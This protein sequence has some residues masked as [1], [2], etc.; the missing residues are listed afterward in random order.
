MNST[1]S[2]SVPSQSLWFD[3]PWNQY[4][5]AN[6]DRYETDD[7]GEPVV[8]VSRDRTCVFVRSVVPGRRD[9]ILVADAWQIERLWERHRIIALLAVLMKIF[10]KAPAAA[11][12]ALQSCHD[13]SSASGEPA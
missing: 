8:F 2:E 11:N 6:M 3:K 12:S 7:P 13:D 5:D 9:R 10:Q 4:C 1:G